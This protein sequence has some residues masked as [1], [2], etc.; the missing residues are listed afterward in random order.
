MRKVVWLQFG[1]GFYHS[2]WWFSWT[3]I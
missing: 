2:W 3:E 1:G